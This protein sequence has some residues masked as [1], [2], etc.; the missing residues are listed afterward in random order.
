MNLQDL[1][2]KREC[3][4]NP[5]LVFRIQL[6]SRIQMCTLWSQ[7]SKIFTYKRILRGHTPKC[8][9]LFY[10][11]ALILFSDIITTATCQAQGSSPSTVV[12]KKD[13]GLSLMKHVNQWLYLGKAELQRD[14]LFFFNLI[15]EVVTYNT[16]V[17]R[18]CYYLKISTVFKTHIVLLY[19]CG[20]GLKNTQ[21]LN[22]A[23]M[24]NKSKAP[25]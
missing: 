18:K 4:L 20:D 23:T 14:F 17:I 24:F 9:H 3:I 11:T 7:F 13:L 5:R 2:G 15:S 10:L 25:D 19:L 12:N 6:R 1:I 8:Q 22:D 16:F 21:N